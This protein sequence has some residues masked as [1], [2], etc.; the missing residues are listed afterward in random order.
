MV[1]EDV[2]R[3]CRGGRIEKKKKTGQSDSGILINLGAIPFLPGCKADTASAARPA[4]P[5]SLT[6][7]SITSATV[8]WDADKTC[9][10]SAA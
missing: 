5:G 4:P 8:I 7:T 2:G 3:L 6:M 9:S 1:D 10:V